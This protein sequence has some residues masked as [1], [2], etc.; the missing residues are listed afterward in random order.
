MNLNDILKALYEENPYLE[1][2]IPEY[3]RYDVWINGLL[4]LE[5]EIFSDNTGSNFF[6]A[7]IKLPGMNFKVE[8]N[9][10][11]KTLDFIYPFFVDHLRKITNDYWVGEAKR[12]G[13]HL[14]WFE[15]FKKIKKD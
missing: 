13:K 1:D 2:K 3:G 7:K 11:L 10:K 8:Y 5:K 12:N 4:V 9:K 15:F 14:F 6:L